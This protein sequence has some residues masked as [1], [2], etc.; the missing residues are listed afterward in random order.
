MAAAF[1]FL[2]MW[3]L[4]LVVA[5]LATLQLGDFFRS[6][7]ELLLV[8]V[9]LA[10]FATVSIAV[11]GIGYALAKR[12]DAFN[13]IAFALAI[14]ALGLVLWPG[15]LARIAART[16]DPYA[17][18]TEQSYI[19]L[20][21][22]I[23]ALLTVLV[24]WGLVRRRWLRAAG[25]EDLTLWPWLTTVVAGLLVLNPFGLAFVWAALRHS[26]GDL[27]KDFA[28]MVAAT[29]AC[30]VVVMGAIECYIRGRIRRRRVEEAQP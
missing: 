6:G 8:I 17:L 26:A 28:T 4:S 23:P 19:A 5:L 13:A 24:Q 16:S 11:L 1:A 20:E 21:L 29:G 2:G 9:A 27:L 30:A 10:A 15:A 7:D 14:V 22:L 25:E 12:A 3:L 18:A